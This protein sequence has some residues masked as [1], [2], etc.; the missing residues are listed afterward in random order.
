MSRTLLCL[1]S[2]FVALTPARADD[3]WPVTRGVSREPAP[4]KYDP[5]S[6]KKLPREF[7]DDSAATI[8]YAGTTHLVEADGT[9]ETITHE[10]TRLNGRKGVEK[11]GEFRNITFAPTYQKV[12]LNIA[13]IH[14]H[15]GKTFE[16]Q[17]RHVHLRDVATDYSVYD[18]D[19]QLIITFPTL[20]V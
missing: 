12:T 18:P 7:L 14:K 11:L 1:A 20:E 8:L 19:K 16:V 5:A 13:R 9:V 15:D 2:L 17:P 4:Y 10:V 6:V 3:A